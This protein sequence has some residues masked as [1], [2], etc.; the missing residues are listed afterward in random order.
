MLKSVNKSVSQYKSAFYQKS[1]VLRTDFSAYKR[2]YMLYHPR[3]FDITRRTEYQFKKRDY[4]QLQFNTQDQLF[5]DDYFKDI[6][7][8]GFEKFYQQ[9]KLKSGQAEYSVHRVGFLMYHMA[10]NQIWDK[11][12]FDEL[13]NMINLTIVNSNEIY[14]RTLYGLLFG[15]YK[16][17][18][19]KNENIY[20]FEKSI[21]LHPPGMHMEMSIPL[22]D[23]ASSSSIID[24]DRMNSNFYSFYKPCFLENWNQQVNFKQRLLAEMCRIFP[25]HKMIDEDIWTKIF[26]TLQKYKRIN[27]LD[28]YDLILKGLLW[29]DSYPE[30]PR[31]KK[32]TKIIEQFK[33]RVRKVENRS[34]KYDVDVLK[35]YIESRI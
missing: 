4:H 28:H 20:F 3:Y 22:F 32:C 30:S 16:F 6:H 11:E 27:N 10:L 13:D 31:Y 7:G 17:N 29:Y 8:K 23:I 5:F 33:D 12:F 1:L 19:G 25:K 34:W 2:N 26:E 9:L 18:R 24:K 21:E 14:I 15:Y 35:I